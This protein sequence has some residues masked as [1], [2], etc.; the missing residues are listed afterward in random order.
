MKQLLLLAVIHLLIFHQ[1]KKDKSE[2]LAPKKDSR[3]IEAIVQGD[4]DHRFRS[5]IARTNE[6]SDSSNISGQPVPLRPTHTVHFLPAI[7]AILK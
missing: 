1:Y 5:T 4:K 3:P 6:T 2:A 7:P